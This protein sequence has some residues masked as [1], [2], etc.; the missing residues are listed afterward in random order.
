MVNDAVESLAVGTRGWIDQ[1]EE[2]N[3]TGFEGAILILCWRDGG[4]VGHGLV[5]VAGFGRIDRWR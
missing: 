5:G 3:M 1:T 4:L 2:P